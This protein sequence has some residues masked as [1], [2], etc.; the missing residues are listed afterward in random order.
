LRTF[1]QHNLFISENTKHN[2]FKGFNE[3][4]TGLSDK[5]LL[6][7]LK[8]HGA[9]TCFSGRSG[10]RLSATEDGIRSCCG[11]LICAYALASRTFHCGESSKAS[12]SVSL[13]VQNCPTANGSTF[14]TSKRGDA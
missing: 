9:R 3:I 12:P 1:K 2:W 6:A 8:L 13:V 11:T 4:Q 10:T 5:Y 14:S 7:G